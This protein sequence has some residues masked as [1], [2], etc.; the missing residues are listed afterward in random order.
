MTPDT[1]RPVSGVGVT[2]GS[3]D[4]GGARGFIAVEGEGEH[5]KKERFVLLREGNG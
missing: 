2:R 3:R 1:E 5:S 4:G